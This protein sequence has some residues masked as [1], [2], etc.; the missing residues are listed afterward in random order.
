MNYFCLGGK[1]VL[2]TTSY[3]KFSEVTK[4]AN[5]LNLWQV[6]DC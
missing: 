4:A 3:V 5:N 6:I 2:R 1:R